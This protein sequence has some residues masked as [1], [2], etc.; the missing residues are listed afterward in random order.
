MDRPLAAYAHDYSRG[1]ETGLHRHRRAELLHPDAVIVE[2]QH[3]PA[4]PGGGRAS[5]PAAR[6]MPAVQAAASA[7]FTRS[8]VN[9]A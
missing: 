8:G 1:H 4:Q 6:R 9:G 5:C 3:H 7:A 2:S